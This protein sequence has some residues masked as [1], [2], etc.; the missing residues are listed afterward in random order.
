[1]VK[2]WERHQ[3]TKQYVIDYQPEFLESQTGGE[4]TKQEEP[5]GRHVEWFAFFQPQE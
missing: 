4:R 5:T 1:M 3:S 2:W